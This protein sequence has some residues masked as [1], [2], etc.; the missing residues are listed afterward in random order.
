MRLPFSSPALEWT[1]VGKKYLWDSFL[2]APW[3]IQGQNSNICPKMK[4]GILTFHSQLNYGGVLQC[5]A[6]QTA[7]EKMGHQVVIIDRWLDPN[8]WYLNRGYPDS[9]WKLKKKTILRSLLGLGD[10]RFFKR[11]QSTRLFIAE[12]LHLTSYH[13]YEWS[14]APKDLGVDIVVVGSDQVWNL[15]WCEAR[16]YLLENAPP[17][18]RRI[19]YAA[20][21]GLPELPSELISVFQ[22]SLANFEVISC[23][24][25]EACDIC[26][27]L[28]FEATHVV[29][30]TLLLD[31]NDWLKLV[32]ISPDECESPAQKKLVCYFLSEDVDR[33][34][35]LLEDF[36]RRNN[37]RVSVLIFDAQRQQDLL[38]LP[39]SPKKIWKWGQEHFRRLSSNV[40][41]YE[42]AGP[43]EFVREHATASWIIT[44]SF[45]SLMFSYIFS[46]RVCFL[47]PKTSYRKL[48]F[49]RIS[50]FCDE[51]CQIS[52][53]FSDLE[54]AFNQIQQPDT[55]PIFNTGKLISFCNN[56]HK[57]IWNHLQPSSH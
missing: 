52:P 33:S 8:N 41:I 20:S 51:Y 28:G 36:S 17:Q 1:G 4:I 24:E 53:I 21:I 30:P 5:W 9:F 23:R 15:S 27:R 6:L 16:F 54:D 57:L 50:N 7:L 26:K 46:K 37:C 31:K 55:N 39:T 10:D 42:D 3:S 29:D 12:K 44:D 38:P 14:E 48:M 18:L 22:T 13:F 19:S 47:S 25:K 32:S 34:L 49:S 45:H 2:W 43:L 56:S 35:P 11:I 40:R